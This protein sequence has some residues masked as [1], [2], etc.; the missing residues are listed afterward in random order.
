MHVDPCYAS[1]T[2]EFFDRIGSHI[3]LKLTTCWTRP[4]R[5]G[6]SFIMDDVANLPGIKPIKLPVY[7][8][9]VR[10][11]LGVTTL[12]DIS[13]HPMMEKPCATGY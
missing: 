5:D 2:W 3:Q 10:L 7:V 1:H 13:A 12:A 8:Q 9:R 6:D 11:F 4:Q